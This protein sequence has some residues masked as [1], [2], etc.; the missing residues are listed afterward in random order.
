MVMA[1][2][3]VK[4][5]G[6]KTGARILPVDS[7]HSAVFHLLERL[8]PG[9]LGEVLLTA[10]GGPFRE[11]PREAFAKLTVTDALKHPTWNM[12]TQI[13]V[14]SA[15]L[16]NK[17][18]EVIEAHFLF[19]VPPERIKVLV[20]PQ[21]I[22]HS[23]VRTKDGVL[24]AQASKPDMRHPILAALTW[25][26]VLPNSLQPL[27]LCGQTL[28]FYPPRPDAFPMLPLAYT[29]IDAGLAACIAYNLANEAAR[30]AFIAGRVEWQD[31][32]RIVEKAM[33]RAVLL[34][35]NT[36]TNIE[37]ILRFGHELKAEV[38]E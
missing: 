3:V 29:A 35:T 13:T 1:G 5:L 32:P 7:E 26:E 24:Y 18:L 16:A 20:H 23:L 31:I 4:A 33:H 21:S 10:S 6:A 17:G 9:S 11:T 8:P 2:P 12:G 27:D 37:D 30:N 25:P 14:D 28:T 36:L 22:V 34:G 38:L 19:D 15:T